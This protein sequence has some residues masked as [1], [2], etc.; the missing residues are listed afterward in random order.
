VRVQGLLRA[1]DDLS[2]VALLVVVRVLEDDPTVMPARIAAAVESVT[3]ATQHHV[4]SAPE[5]FAAR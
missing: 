1:D 4:Y 2:F 5:R 3:A